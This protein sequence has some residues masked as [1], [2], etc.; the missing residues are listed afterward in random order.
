MISSNGHQYEPRN[1]ELPKPGS[2]D[3]PAPNVTKK[4]NA[5]MDKKE[6]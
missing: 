5:E 1:I 3:L 6:I 4:K 2:I